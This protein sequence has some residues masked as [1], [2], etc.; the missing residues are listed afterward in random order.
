M[1]RR[2]LIALLWF[3]LA[4]IATPEQMGELQIEPP[5]GWQRSSANGGVRFLLPSDNMGSGCQIT[6]RPSHQGG[7][8]PRTD[9]EREWLAA[10]A[11]TAINTVP[12]M[13]I[14]QIQD[15]WTT[16]YGG[17]GEPGGQ[18]SQILLI[19]VSRMGIVQGV[20]ASGRDPRCGPAFNAFFSALDIAQPRIST[21]VAAPSL[22]AQVA[23]VAAVVGWWHGLQTV[24]TMRPVGFTGTQI[25]PQTGPRDLL[26]M[27]DGTYSEDI[28]SDGIDSESLRRGRP[29]QQGRYT[30]DG[31]TIVLH[32]AEGATPKTLKFSGSEL[33]AETGNLQ[34]RRSVD[35]L[36]LDGVYS[37]ELPGGT[38][39]DE[40]TIRFAADGNFTDYGALFRVCNDGL[41]LSNSACNRG[42]SGHYEVMTNTLTLRF[43]DGRVVRLT[44]FYSDRNEIGMAYNFRLKRRG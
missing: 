22:P 5:A 41:N 32:N 10:L 8:D 27:P 6:V 3:P 18:Q 24:T 19:T 7:V 43:D 40:P 14:K 12:P 13:E 39:N 4:A 25:G 9:F 29:L 34:H 30:F 35:G 20:L 28:P 31:S 44:V 2:T 36:H 26:L 37:A 33:L 23:G 15:G 42:G 17:V 38:L 16:A 1:E 21:T 11:G